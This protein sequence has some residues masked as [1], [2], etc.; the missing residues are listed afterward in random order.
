VRQRGKTELDYF[1]A[2][3]S[4]QDASIEGDEPCYPMTEN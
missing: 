2:T 3:L 1:R 4:D